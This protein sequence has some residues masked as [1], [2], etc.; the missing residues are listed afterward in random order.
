[1][2]TLREK[3]RGCLLGAAIGDIVGAVVEAESP[4][5]IAQNYHGID[6]ILALD[7]VPEFT[8]PDWRVGRYTDDTQM[9]ICV[10][11]WLLDGP[12][13][14]PERLLT[15]FAE[16]HQPWRRYGPGTEA[17]FR[18]Y[19]EHR[20]EWRQL[21]TAAFPE[22]SHGNGSAM[23]VAPVG[24]AYFSDLKTAATVAQESS[25]PTHSHP[26]AYQG[27]VLQC[28]A[29]AIATNLSEFSLEPFL[30]PMR[31]S[32]AWFSDLLWDTSKFTSALDAIEH[33]LQHSTSCL[34]MSSVLGNGI[35]AHE[36]VP[37]AL[38]CFL[39]HSESYAQV[40]HEAVFVGG[41]TDTI[42]CMAGAISGAFL[43]SSAIP[44]GWLGAVREE[45]YS[46]KAIEILADRIL[47][48]FYRV[49]D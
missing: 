3:F 8:G 40:L 20:S 25:R 39:R 34:E 23:R 36:A 18:L 43:G 47:E 26:R 17:I 21:S 44:A 45:T 12:P 10:A 27:A 9:M 31:E 37:M 4:G 6:D 14:L 16:A 5:Y 30:Q 19:P 32:L 7:S 13:H 46:P 41:D 33:G 2:A 1:M 42:A 48:K 28:L 29:V 49:S 22:G 11:E 35:V 24:L 15:R 38:Y